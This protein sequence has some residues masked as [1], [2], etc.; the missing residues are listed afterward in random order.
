MAGIPP[1]AGFFGKFYIFVAAAK[2]GPAGLSLLWL[3]ILAIAASVISLYYYLLVLKQAY[4][5]NPAEGA[6]PA[7]CDLAL[8][9]TAAVL[10]LV[11]VVAGCF[12]STILLLIQ[13]AI[14]AGH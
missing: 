7:R 5:A 2:G 12:P 13:S 9:L 6:A 8:R 3:V 11:V 14:G 4:V 1:L 10:A